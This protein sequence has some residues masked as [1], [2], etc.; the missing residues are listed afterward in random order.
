MKCS[1]AL[2]KPPILKLNKLICFVIDKFI[3]FQFLLII[4]KIR[5]LSLIEVHMDYQILF[6]IQNLK[7]EPYHF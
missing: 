6:F 7:Q 1:S 5:C 2:I 3:I 4:L